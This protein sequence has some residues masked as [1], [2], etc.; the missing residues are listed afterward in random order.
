[1]G[2]KKLKDQLQQDIEERLGNLKTPK[3]KKKPVSASQIFITFIMILVTL[4][5]I[6]SLVRILM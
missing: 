2:D 5:I 3:S 4:G 6:I 1:M